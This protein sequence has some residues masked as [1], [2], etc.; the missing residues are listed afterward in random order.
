MRS[1]LP[2]TFSVRLFNNTVCTSLSHILQNFLKI[3]EFRKVRTIIY[4]K[5]VIESKAGSP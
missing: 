3:N 4:M 2:D 1:K 5:Q